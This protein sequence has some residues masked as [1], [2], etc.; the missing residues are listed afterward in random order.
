MRASMCGPGVAR[1]LGEG[2]L[3]FWAG[4]ISLS[5]LRER[6]PM[7]GREPPIIAVARGQS[8]QQVQQR[9]FL[10]NATGTADQAIGECGGSEHKSIARPGVQVRVL[11]GYCG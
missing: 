2:S 10:P 6:H 4:G 1:V 11:R 5:I 3:D 8:V 9:V 7:M